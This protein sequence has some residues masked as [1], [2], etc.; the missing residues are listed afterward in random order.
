MSTRSPLAQHSDQPSVEVRRVRIPVVR[1]PHGSAHGLLTTYLDGGRGEAIV[2]VHG[3]GVGG[4]GQLAWGAVAKEM[5]TTHRVIAPD[6]LWSGWSDIPSLP[7]S[8]EAQVDQ[9]V[10]LLDV[11]D[12]DR[13]ALVGQSMGAYVAA[14]CACDYPE[15]VT[16]LCLVASNTVSLSMGLE[17]PP[18]PGLAAKDALDGSRERMQQ[19][20]STL[21]HRKDLITD[22]ELGAWVAIAE[23][24][25]MAEARASLSQYVRELGD[26]ANRRQSFALKG[27]LDQLTLPMALI[28][29]RND[30][31][32]SISL[33]SQLRELVPFRL[34]REIDMAGHGVFR[35]QPGE[36]SKVLREFLDA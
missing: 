15:R 34:Y 21:Y 20:L 26:N 7:Y 31:F 17:L 28:W 36:F 18:T 5:A 22:D 10:G 35:D 8:L 11:L 9:V 1:G 2:F 25:G 27:R 32:A 4:S 29:G 33:A 12:I 13:C 30:Q 16:R 6:L 19:L 24:P 23:R 3:S 14:R